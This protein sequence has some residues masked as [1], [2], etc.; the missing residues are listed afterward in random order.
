M[1]LVRGFEVE[2]GE[3]NV[4]VVVVAVCVAHKASDTHY[5]THEK[6]LSVSPLDV[7]GSTPQFHTRLLSL[8]SARWQFSTLHHIFPSNSPLLA[9]VPHWVCELRNIFSRTGGSP[10]GIPQLR[11]SSLGEIKLS[12]VRTVCAAPLAQVARVVFLNSP[13][14]CPICLEPHE[15]YAATLLRCSHTFHYACIIPWL[16]MGHTQCPLCRL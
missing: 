9:N 15:Q 4:G 3:G 6:V 1:H 8:H 7:M 2:L 16:Q 13:N 11:T 10:G 5:V 12:T 14:N